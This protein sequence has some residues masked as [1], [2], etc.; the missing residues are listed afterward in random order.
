ME[1]KLL[2]DIKEL[3]EALRVVTDY[4]LCMQAVTKY[5]PNGSPNLLNI[6]RMVNN[7]KKEYEI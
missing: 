2:K 6:M 3:T 1:D 7:I 4:T 5:K